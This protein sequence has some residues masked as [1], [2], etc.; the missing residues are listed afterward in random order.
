MLGPVGPGGDVQAEGAESWRT[1]R[2]QKRVH[3]VASRQQ[4]RQAALNQIGAGQCGRNG[5]GLDYRTAAT[6]AELSSGE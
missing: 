1:N 4:V 6:L 5:H 3:R 2:D